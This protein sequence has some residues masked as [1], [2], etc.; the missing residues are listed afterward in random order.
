M[1]TKLTVKANE[2]STFVIEA[3]FA[4]ENGA[5][6]TPNSGLVWTLTDAAGK[7]INNKASVAIAPASTVTI[8]LSGN[9]LAAGQ[10]DDLRRVLTIEGTYNSSLGNNLPLKDQAEFSLYNLVAVQ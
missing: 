8:V 9:D 7:V 4:D 10:L 5:A 3:R 2:K 1:P 6:V